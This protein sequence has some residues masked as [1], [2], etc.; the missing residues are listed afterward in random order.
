MMVWS[1]NA[2]ANTVEIHMHKS[3]HL[4]DILSEIMCHTKQSL[5]ACS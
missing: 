5:T 1:E 3:N 2:T 4:T